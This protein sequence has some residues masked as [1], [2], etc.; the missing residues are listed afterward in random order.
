[1]I[2][3]KRHVLDKLGQQL[4]EADDEAQRRRKHVAAGDTAVA[5]AREKI[6]CSDIEVQACA[7][8][9]LSAGVDVFVTVSTYACIQT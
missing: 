9:F 6:K 2:E 8:L 5:S 7:A 1:M 3:D 4:A